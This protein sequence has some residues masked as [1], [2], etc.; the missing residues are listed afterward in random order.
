MHADSIVRVQA[1]G[2]YGSVF[3]IGENGIC[4]VGLIDP[5]ADDYS[6]MVPL[7]GLDELAKPVGAE[8]QRLID[9]LAL[10]HIEINKPR[11]EGYIEL[12]VGRSE[13]GTMKLWFENRSM[14]KGTKFT[15]SDRA[16]DEVQ[17]QDL[18][19]VLSNFDL[20]ECRG[21]DAYSEGILDGWSWSA[22]FIGA[23]FAQSGLG[24]NVAPTAFFDLI[25]VLEQFGLPIDT[26]A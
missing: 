25:H 2:S 23:G 12:F 16:L 9:E 10:L 14:I 20:S 21:E 17:V 11:W 8:R 6:L 26:S 24:H 13:E 18:K 7:S 19:Q 3:E 1:T 15:V 22:E 4:E 5:L